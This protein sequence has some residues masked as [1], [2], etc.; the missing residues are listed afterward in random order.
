MVWRIDDPA[1][2]ESAKVMWELPQYT[3]G[4]GLDIGCGP[5]KAFP[6]MIGVDNYTD[7]QLFGIQMKP[8]V[9]SDC[10]KLEVFGSASMD[11]VYSSHLL[12]HVEFEKVAATLREWARL[13][14]Q[15]GYLILYLPD[16]A[17]YPQCGE[18]GANPDHKWNVNYQKVVDAMDSV[19]RNW[20]LIRYEQRHQEREYSLFFVFK[21]Q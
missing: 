10:T 21:L 2:N 6:H 1:G 14:K 19:P 17:A 3:R 5:S 18:E 9:V 11:F 20:D 7:T 16:E 15:G 13:V 4:R 12:E 8:D